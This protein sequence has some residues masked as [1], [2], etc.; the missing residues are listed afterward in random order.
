MAAKKYYWVNPRKSFGRG[1][2]FGDEM[3]KLDAERVKILKDQKA[4][5]DK[6]PVTWEEAQANELTA[7]NE[8]IAELEEELE[9]GGDKT[10]TDKI[11]TLEDSAKLD[12]D[13][14][15]DLE[16][17]VEDLTGPGEGAE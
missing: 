9:S 10:L 8:R 14:I 12:A 1:V 5:S 3:P 17:Q 16:K 7:A 13:K 6:K 2:K 11:A 4:I 15:E